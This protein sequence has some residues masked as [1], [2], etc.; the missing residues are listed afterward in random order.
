MKKITYYKAS[1]VRDGSHFPHNVR[2]TKSE[3]YPLKITTKK[4][5][6]FNFALEFDRTEGK[7]Y[8]TEITTGV[9]TRYTIMH[10]DKNELARLLQEL[11]LE[12]IL[13][14]SQN[15]VLRELL[16]EHITEETK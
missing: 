6:E 5:N 3:G 1:T 15:T 2:F 11:E 10:K 14:N 12:H 8:A 13:E 9:G 16:I 4:G 7:W